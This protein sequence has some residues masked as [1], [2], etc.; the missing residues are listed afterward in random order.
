[1]AANCLPA[2]TACTSLFK[3]TALD[4]GNEAIITKGLL[5]CM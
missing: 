5:R 1:M 3:Q 4:M 2:L